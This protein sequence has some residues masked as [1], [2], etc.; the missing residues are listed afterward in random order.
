MTGLSGGPLVL[1]NNAGDDLSLMGD[2]DFTFPI[3]VADGS[4]YAVTVLTRPT[5]P[6]QTCLVTGGTGTIA[7]ADVADVAVVC[8]TDTFTVGGTISGLSGTVVL[9]NNGAD[10]LTLTADGDFTFDTALADGGS[11]AV[12]V[13]S[14]PTGQACTVGN[15]TGTVSGADVSAVAVTCATDTGGGD[16]TNT[17]P[18]ALA[19]VATLDEDTFVNIA[20]AASDDDGDSLTYSVVDQPSGGTVA[21]SGNFAIYTPY[22]DV[23]GTDSFTFKANDGSADSNTATVTVT[24]NPINDAPV[25]TNA[26]ATSGNEETAYSYLPA[27]TDVDV[28]DTKAFSITGTLPGWLS[29]SIATGTLGGTPGYSDAGA[30]GPF[31]I[32]VTDG[33]GATGSTGSFT[34]TVSNVTKTLSIAKAGAGTGTV[35]SSPAGIDCG[36]DGSE[37]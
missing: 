16:G 3:E 23:N 32:T 35:T 25:I 15:G 21:I 24:V 11:Y 33:G 13:F 6:S 20:L 37:V 28:G 12:T 22:Q 27:V 17:A 5:G 36:A 8:S 9:Q 1:Q 29:F 2:G 26:P 31:E 14:E 7:G 10:D 4:A 30:Y 34:I 19:G 18:V